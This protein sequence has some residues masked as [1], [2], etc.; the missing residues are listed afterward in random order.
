VADT[1][2]WSNLARQVGQGLSFGFSDE[3]EAALR[4]LAQFDPAQ[5][6]AI[7]DRIEAQRRAWAEAN[8]GTAMGAETV[9]ALVPGVV[10]AFV[11][12]G[13]GATV[14][15]LARIARVMDAPVE[16]FAARVAP[17]ALS[18]LQSTR[19]GRL[20]VGVA[21]EAATGAVQSAGE[22][23]T[24][25]DIPQE[26]LDAAPMNFLSS[27]AVR[28]ATGAGGLAVKRIRKKRK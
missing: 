6:R 3:G 27:L 12:G 4:A 11:P 24:I 26:V 19:L 17:R 7:K 18:A 16:R 25:Q 14:G 23:R 28:G 10:G 20:G 13:Q 8:P 15:S 22:G 2:Y 21:D 5:Y 1:S 9:G